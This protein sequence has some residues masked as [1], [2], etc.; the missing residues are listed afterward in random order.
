MLLL[1]LLDQNAGDLSESLSILTLD[2][3]K[4]VSVL[5]CVSE[6]LLPL[7]QE[8]L[9]SLLLLRHLFLHYLHHLVSQLVHQAAGAPLVSA[10][11]RGVSV[12]FY[13][14]E[15]EGKTQFWE[16]LMLFYGD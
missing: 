10:T 2:S 1:V 9:N 3:L 6:K 7:G 12:P 16:K 8:T 11:D 14:R 13:R 15:G 5:F 4:F